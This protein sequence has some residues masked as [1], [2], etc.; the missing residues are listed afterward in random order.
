MTK[1]V[2]LQ[3]AVNQQ[4]DAGLENT[5][6]S[7]AVKQRLNQVDKIRAIGVGDH[8]SLPQLVVCGA[9]SAGK[10]SVL[11]GIT[12][13]PF[14]RQDGV[15]TKFATEIILRHS[16]TET[17]ITAS[18]IPHKERDPEEANALRSFRRSLA[19][20]GELPDVIS[21]AAQRMGIRGFGNAGDD[22]PAFSA[23]VLRIEAIGNTGLHLTVVDLP[24]LISVDETGGE[25][26]R[27]VENLVDSYLR[28]SRTIILAVVRATNDI[29]TEPIIQRARDFDS[30]GERT[31]GIITKADLIN[32]GTEDR[33]AKFTKN[34]DQTKLK[35][36]YFV[37]KNPS[38]KEINEGMT[39]VQRKRAEMQFFQ[40]T[41]W[42]EHR[43][44]MSRVGIDALRS[45]LASLLETHIE[46]ELPKVCEEIETL[47]QRT[48][49]EIRDLGKER[50]TIGEQRSFLSELSMEFHG[51]M[52]AAL[53]GT[54]QNSKSNFFGYGENELPHSRLR[55]QYHY[56]N[57][58]FANY[59]RER[60][61]KRKIASSEPASEEASAEG[62]ENKPQAG[63]YSHL[64]K[65]DEG[66]IF[67]SEDDFD[68]WVQTVR[69]A[70]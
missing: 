54:Y 21:D 61:Q 18:I 28:N 4:S 25:D 13:I 38:P 32:R 55:A 10:S 51:L 57:D 5:L 37:L 50:S 46:R 35:L 44:N 24:G 1:T 30:S 23:D 62:M 63:L 67:L 19:G 36:G 68:S 29:V 12:G 39:L 7:A 65:S 17:S 33:I 64:E 27:L 58:V 53:D 3:N 69:S 42:Q 34:Q 31:V 45:F 14:P 20:Y 9:Q 66:P 40:S 48:Q 2:D 8:I 47:L 59:M 56:L 11:E 52:Q 60:S 43:L 49:D 6:Q 15:C 41:Q 22:A 70:S 16:L 26:I